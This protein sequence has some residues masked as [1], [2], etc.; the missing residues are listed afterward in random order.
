MI[1]DLPYICVVMSEPMLVRLFFSVL[2]SKSPFVLS[3][4]YRG[5]ESGVFCLSGLSSE[6]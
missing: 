1:M 3:N 6:I 4:R 5:S 2:C